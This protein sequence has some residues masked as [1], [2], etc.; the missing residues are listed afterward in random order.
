MPTHIMMAIAL[1]ASTLKR[2]NWIIRDFLWHGRRDTSVGHCLV[3]WHKVCHPLALGGL[4]I[5]DLRRF[6]IA[7]CTRWCWLQRT[8]PAR[9]WCHLRI[10]VDADTAAIFY[11]STTWALADGCEYRFWV[12]HWLNGKATTKVAP[13]IAS[14]IPRRRRNA[15]TVAEGLHLRSWVRDMQGALSPIAMVEYINL[16]HFLGQVTLSSEPNRLV[17]RWTMSSV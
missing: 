3:N 16:W 1:S 6:S 4:G 7:L 14:L 11:A 15:W 17:W 2:I 13:T 5:P 9:P 8:D 10:P 12:D